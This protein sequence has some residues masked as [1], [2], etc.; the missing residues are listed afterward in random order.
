MFERRLRIMLLILALPVATVA[1]RIVDLQVRHAD[2]YREATENMLYLEPV[3]FPCL[4]GDISDRN[5]VRL[6]YDAPA[7]DIGI[8]Y[9]AISGNDRYLRRLARLLAVPSEVVTP[10]RIEE[11]FEILAEI[12]GRPPSEIRDQV[13][14]IRRNVERIR[15][16]VAIR[17]GYEMEVREE[18]WVHTLVSG[19]DRQQQL[20]A[21]EKLAAYPWLEVLAG[22]IRRY[23]GGPAFG[24]VLGRMA[25]VSLDDLRDDPHAEDSLTRYRLDDVRGV[26]G[27]EAL[28]E[29]YI[30]TAGRRWLRGRRGRVHEDR[31]KRPLSP[32]VEPIDGENLIMTIDAE[33]QRALYEQLRE[34]VLGN[35]FSSGG[36]VVLLHTRTREVLALVDYPSYDANISYAELLDL[37]K[38]D[39]WGKP[40]VCRAIGGDYPPGS[41]VKPMI[42]AAALSAGKVTASTSYYCAGRLFPDLPGRWGCTSHHGDMGPIPALQKSCNVYFYHTGEI[43]GTANLATWLPRFG[44]SRLNGTGLPEE[45]S[46]PYRPPS[47]VGAA[48]HTA[49][50]QFPFTATPLQVANMM[51]TIATG[52]YRPVVLWSN[53]PRPRPSAERL[54]VSEA[55]WAIVREGLFEAVNMPGGTAYRHVN[56][57]DMSDYV[58]LGKTGSAETGRPLP[59]HAW[60]VGYLTDRG[61]YRSSSATCEASVAIALVIELAGHG[62]DRA[63]P[64]VSEMLRT[65]LKW[66]WPESLSSSAKSRED[67]F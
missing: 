16:N 36:S 51:A 67:A 38:K 4:R 66:Y 40:H 29:G 28:G 5:G 7:W 35:P 22:K 64:V 37:A 62:G 21:R 42:L 50:G 52:E 59:T 3:F 61:R 12:A 55:H 34:A 24:H 65:Y 47:T 57:S 25:P 43:M 46:R 13:A 60:F 49:I 17:Y 44:F 56:L 33:L 53:D 15:E 45:R 20:T 27:A 31:K 30:P 9:E 11:S 39:T 23:E 63:V 54:P 6:A 32:P 41:T 19:L 14:G 10:A 58:L 2:K 1:Y 48:R 8:R 18:R 26:R